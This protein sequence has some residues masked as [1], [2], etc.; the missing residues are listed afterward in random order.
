MIPLF[1]AKL[2]DLDLKQFQSSYLNAPQLKLEDIL[3]TPQEQK[4]FKNNLIFTILRIIVNHGGPGFKKFREDLDKHQPET[5][6]KIPVHTTDLHPL[7]SWN[8]DE[9]SIV[10]NAEVDQAIVNELRLDGVP[11]AADRVRFLGG[12]QLS[13]ARLRALE[14]IRAGQ[15][16]GYEGFFWGAWIP[17]LFHAKIADTHGTLLNH[18][19]KPES[20]AQ[21]PW[22][23]GFQNSRLDRLPITLT[24]LPTF[25]TSRDLIFVSLYARVLHCLCLASKF[26]SLEEYALKVDKW[27]TLVEHATKIY[28]SFANSALVEELRSQRA[29]CLDRQDEGAKPGEGDAVFENASLFLRDALISREF[30]DAIKAGDSGRV[31]LV[32]KLWALSFRGNGRT[33]YAYE[34]LHLI[35]NLTSVWPKPIR[36]VNSVT[37]SRGVKVYS[38]GRNIVMKNWLLNPSGLPNRFVEMDLAQEHLN[39]RVKVQI[40]LKIYELRF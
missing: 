34:M 30:N 11:G 9:S 13:L 32:L 8:I 5:A 15:E 26:R 27:E 36:F 39:L 28:Q 40:L 6:E 1:D 25:R 20:A 21:S 18:F 7:P 12:D 10:G 14:F 24:S 17:G 29:E 3:H 31:I 23:L 33:K 35:H 16:E 22:S 19:G 38:R 37:Y 4:V 2:E